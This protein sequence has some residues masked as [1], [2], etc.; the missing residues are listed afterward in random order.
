M[1]FF[2]MAVLLKYAAAPTEHVQAYVT[3][4]MIRIYPSFVHP[5]LCPVF[6]LYFI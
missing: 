4:V 1:H 3:D 5:E 2:D 6:A